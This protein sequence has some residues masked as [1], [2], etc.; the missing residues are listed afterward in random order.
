MDFTLSDDQ[1]LLRDTARNLLAKE[2]P[3]SLVRAHIDDRAAA[4]PL[5]KHLREYT[6]LGVGPL[7]DLCL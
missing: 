5:W 7:A 3:V 6:A 1:Q 4:D 2:C